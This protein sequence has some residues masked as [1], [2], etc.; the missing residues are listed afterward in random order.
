MYFRSDRCV[1][2]ESY[3]ECGTPCPNKCGQT[4][5]QICTRECASP[6]CYCT[7]EGYARNSLGKCVPIKDC[8]DPQPL[9]RNLLFL[10]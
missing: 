2:G 9:C 3:M 4:G 8:P 7:K 5:P 6:G 10:N 1:E